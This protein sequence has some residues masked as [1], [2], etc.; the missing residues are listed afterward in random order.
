L[1]GDHERPL[2]GRA[3]GLR[4]RDGRVAADGAVTMIHFHP[5]KNPNRLTLTLGARFRLLPAF[6]HSR[7]SRMGCGFFYISWLG[8]YVEYNH[9][10]RAW[11]EY[12]AVAQ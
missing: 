8:A 5:I 2:A 6:G 4:G 3:L 11:R 7:R 1:T 9:L 12:R 10:S